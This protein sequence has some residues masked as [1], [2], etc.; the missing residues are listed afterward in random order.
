MPNVSSWSS[1]IPFLPTEASTVAGR[2]DA[3][4]LFLIAVSAFFVGLILLLV[5]VFAVKY[6][7][8]SQDEQPHQIHGSLALELVWTVI[9]LGIALV[10]FFWAA[11]L[12]FT[13]SS[14]P[15]NGI[16][17]F[18]V[19]K[20]WMWKLQHPEGHREINELHVPVGRPVKL[21]MTS[22][23]VIHSFFVPAFR[24]K[25]DVV[26]GRYTTAWF[27]ATKP[28]EYR[29]FCSQYCGLGHASMTGR[30]IVMPEDQYEAWLRGG[31]G[32]ASPAAL[33]EQLFNQFGCSGCHQPKGSGPGPSLVGVFDKP[34]KL[35]DGRTV[36]ADEGYV[37]ES[38]LYPQAKVVAGY[39]PIMP[40]FKGLIGEDDLLN[41]I[42]YIKSLSTEQKAQAQ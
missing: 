4:L 8:R 32:G 9:P 11:G 10:I 18:V 33:G 2:V 19:G 39:M 38:I 15:T 41:L 30:I 27:Q 42:A 29:L 37:R 16:D 22:E 1:W 21:T 7:R 3:L 17:I 26:P 24:I 31:T 14:P 6:R 35:Q 28:G 34:V 23:D 13:L 5:A 25:K 12:Y 36:I 20:Q 40:T